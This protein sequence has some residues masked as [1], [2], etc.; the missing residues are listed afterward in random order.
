MKSRAA[1]TPAIPYTELEIELLKKY[2]PICGE[3]E[4]KN[5]L[6]NRSFI[7]IRQKAGLLGLKIEISRSRRGSLLPLLNGTPEAFYWLG[8]FL[9]D[10]HITKTGQFVVYLSG[11]DRNHLEKLA[12][13]LGTTVTNPYN[14]PNK[15]YAGT[16]PLLAKLPL[17]EQERKIRQMCRIAVSHPQAAC[18]IR[19]LLGLTS[20]HKTINPPNIE[21]LNLLDNDSLTSLFIGFFDGDGSSS[22]IGSH[23]SWHEVHL[24]FKQRNLADTIKLTTKVSS[25]YVFKEHI[26]KI[27]K[28]AREQ[29]LPVLDRKWNRWDRPQHA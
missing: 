1:K 22:G 10:G 19:E 5:L 23:S 18:Q 16:D 13:F 26:I 11:K 17:E 28:F 4:F 29:N 21:V 24:L 12:K 7:G 6:P 27:C 8:F 3:K 15:I 2:W 14:N 25:L 9:A 20:S